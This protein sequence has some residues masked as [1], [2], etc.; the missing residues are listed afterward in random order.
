M[1]PR[2]RNAGFTLI[3][4]LVVVAII[5][6]LAAIAMPAFQNSQGKALDASVKEHAR[7]AAA[8]E[9]AYYVDNASYYA[10]PCIDLPGMRVSQNVACDIAVSGDQYDVTTSHPNARLTCV[11]S[12]HSVPSL[13]CN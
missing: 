2:R 5:G 12:N 9:E 6:V 10:G 8:A 4:L 7:N 1:R 11:Y 13:D 3:E